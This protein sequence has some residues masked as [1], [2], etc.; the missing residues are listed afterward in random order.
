[1]GLEQDVELLGVL[2]EPQRRR[3]YEEL[4]ASSTPQTLSE[5][6]EVL[7]VG[8]TLTSFHL[9]KLVE[10]G[11]V[12]VLAPEPGSGR[13]G[14]PS[15]RYRVSDREVS[16]SIPARRYDVVADVLLE[17]AH[18]QQQ[19]EPIEAAAR[20]AA[21]RRGVELAT[22]EP[23]QRRAGVLKRAEHLLSRLGYSP[24][25]VDGDVVLRNCPFDK[26]RDTNCELVCAIN[27]ALAE[28]YLAGLGAAGELTA[29][30]RPCPDNCCVVVS[31]R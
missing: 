3:V 20:R 28:G 15:Q 9:G 18:D 6:S 2:V 27:H 26:L 16:A 30:L 5:L 25:R 22:E 13:R 31:P 23:P 1:V 17:A 8:R 11:F 14:R 21:V 12:E 29:S 24:A 4:L 19:G 10:A 7:G